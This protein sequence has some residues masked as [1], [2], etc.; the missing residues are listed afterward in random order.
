MLHH[1]RHGLI[2]AAVVHCVFYGAAGSHYRGGGALSVV[3]CSRFSLSR[4][5]F[6]ECCSMQQV[7]IIAA[8]VRR[9]LYYAAGSHYR[10]GTRMLCAVNK[11]LLPAW[12]ELFEIHKF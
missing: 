11:A 4:R 3:L 12:A 6:A 7:L 9:M 8:V 5:W 10:G 1:M 2:I